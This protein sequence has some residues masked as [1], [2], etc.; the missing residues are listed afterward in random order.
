[1][2]YSIIMKTK[3]ILI[4]WPESQ[5]FLDGEHSNECIP[6]FNEDP[7]YKQVESS[8]IMVPYKIYLHTM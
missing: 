7:K 5:E 2:S 6:V 4:E 1:M 8:S 3:Y